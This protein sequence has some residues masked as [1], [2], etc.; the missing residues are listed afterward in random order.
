MCGQLDPTGNAFV[1][2][3]VESAKRTAKAPVGKKDPVS[4][5]ILLSFLF[6][7]QKISFKSD[8]ECNHCEFHKFHKKHHYFPFQVQ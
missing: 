6:K 4:T 7:I 8:L 1:K 3:L 2:N 5:D